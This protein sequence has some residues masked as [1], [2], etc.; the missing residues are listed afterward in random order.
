[1]K[2][3]LEVKNIP[4]ILRS[5]RVWIK[6]QTST[7]A[8]EIGLVG[9]N[10]KILEL[11][12]DCH[13]EIVLHQT[14]HDQTQIELKVLHGQVQVVTVEINHSWKINPYFYNK[15]PDQI[16]CF[17]NSEF[18]VSMVSQ[19]FFQDLQLYDLFE[20]TGDTE[21]SATTNLAYN[22]R[23]NQDVIQDNNLCGDLLVNDHLIFDVYVTSPAIEKKRSE[24]D[25]NFNFDFAWS[26]NFDQTIIDGLD[27]RFYEFVNKKLTNKNVNWAPETFSGYKMP[28]AF[29]SRIQSQLIDN[30]E[31]IK[32]RH[33]VDLGCERGQFL[34]PCTAL[35]CASVTGVQPLEDYNHVINEALAHL[36]LQTQAS[37]V[38]G[39]VYDLNYLKNQLVGKDT[40]LCLGLLY[41]LN[42]HYQFLQ[43]I[44]SSDVSALIIDISIQNKHMLDF[45]CSN[46]PD[47]RYWYE[48]H[49]VDINGW[50]LLSTTNPN[51]FVG[52]P[53]AAWII[54]CLTHLGWT[55]KSNVLQSMVKLPHLRYRG[56]ISFYR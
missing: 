14:A 25:Q 28:Y 22:V 42:H 48:K 50:E 26:Q 5:F 1:M 46:T 9:N 27:L 52:T 4:V 19:E 21:F 13:R 33:V 35:G 40:V 24:F 34:F 11:D 12:N 20:S 30:V 3:S 7:A 38:Y 15:Y 29:K 18:D 44:S 36:N 8:I 32:D 51:T 54:N 31:F 17:I 56:V 39:N 53:N 23:L 47:I 41:H 10:K 2:I 55:V 43:T 45:Y 16:N 49:G 6:S 37:A